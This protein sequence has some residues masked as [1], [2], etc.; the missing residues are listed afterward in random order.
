LLENA[1]DGR[2]RSELGAH[3][4]PRSFVERLVLPTVMEPLRAEWD[5]AKAG[6]YEQEER[7]DRPAAAAIVRAFH[8]RLCAIRVLDPACG[9]GNFLYVTMELMKRLEG[10]VLDLLAARQSR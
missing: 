8:A 3:F 4:T 9:S 5:G 10:E 6:A 2:Q 7:G 1:L